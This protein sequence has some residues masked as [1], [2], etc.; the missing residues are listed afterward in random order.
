MDKL[1]R[2]CG[3]KLPIERFY[4]HP[5]MADGHLN[6]CMECVKTRVN[7]HRV[8]NIEKIRAYDRERGK[9]PHRIKKSRVET[10]K[11][12]EKTGYGKVHEALERAVKK[13]ICSKSNMCQICSATTKLEAHHF[14]YSK[15]LEV[16][17]LCQPCHRQ[18]HIGK[19]DRAKM[20]KVIVDAISDIRSFDLV[21]T[22]SMSV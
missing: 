8:D 21:K 18:Y 7:K 3:K 19:S 6:I 10:R 2:K 5:K 12:R 4:T 1:C 22:Q 14:D 15:P 11:R 13:G 20:V 17:W 16:I 9:L